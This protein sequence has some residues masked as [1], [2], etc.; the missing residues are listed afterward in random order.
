MA[1]LRMSL[2]KQQTN[3]HRNILECLLEAD[4]HR[5]IEIHVG[6]RAGK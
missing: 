4:K 3:R 1:L 5:L 2:L 6:I